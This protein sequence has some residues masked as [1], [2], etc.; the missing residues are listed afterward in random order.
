MFLKKL[1]NMSNGN[2]GCQNGNSNFYDIKTNHNETDLITRPHKHRII[3][4]L[5]M[6]QNILAQRKYNLFY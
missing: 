3:Y 2:N 6:G 5:W 1:F 4:L